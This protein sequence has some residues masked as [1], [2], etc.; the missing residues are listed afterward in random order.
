[1]RVGVCELVLLRL[2]LWDKGWLCRS[3]PGASCGPGREF[4]STAPPP[5]RSSPS[6]WG[7]GYSRHTRSTPDAGICPALSQPHHCWGKR[8]PSWTHTHTHTAKNMTQRETTLQIRQVFHIQER[9]AIKLGA[10]V[11]LMQLPGRAKTTINLHG[12]ISVVHVWIFFR[13]FFSQT[14]FLFFFF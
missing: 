13:F 6:V 12:F 1:M 8:R 4:H 11:E 2:R 3:P 5:R 10:A 14:S 7:W 9:I